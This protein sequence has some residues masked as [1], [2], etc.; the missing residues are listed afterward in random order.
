MQIPHFSVYVRVQGLLGTL[1]TNANW[2]TFLSGHHFHGRIFW[3]NG[4]FSP[5]SSFFLLVHYRD[6]R[7]GWGRGENLITRTLRREGH[8]PGASVWWLVR[9]RWRLLTP[10]SMLPL[11]VFFFFYSSSTFFTFYSHHFSTPDTFPE[12]PSL[13]HFL[14]YTIHSK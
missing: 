1:E 5:S 11:A 10:L 14:Y 3:L 13:S 2:D 9:E 7:T 12:C 4:I 8:C 6:D